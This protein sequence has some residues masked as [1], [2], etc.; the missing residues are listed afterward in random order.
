M[1]ADSEQLIRGKY[2]S[3]APAFNEASLRLWV[4]AEARSLGRGGVSTV[5]RATGLSRNTVMA[6]LRELD[7]PAHGSR[8]ASG[9]VRR[10]GGGRK[11]AT[12]VQ[13]ELGA[14]LDQLVSPATRGDPMS[15][16]PANARETRYYA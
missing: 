12:A 11:R 5:S 10:P 4:A 15:R 7:D 9:R 3:L 6:G 13:P 8:L 14:A 2:E 1:I 16:G